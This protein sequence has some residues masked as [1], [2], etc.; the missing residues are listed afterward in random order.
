MKKMDEQFWIAV[1]E[2]WQGFTSDVCQDTPRLV[3]EV[4]R[5]EA[6][7]ERVGRL[8]R[9]RLTPDSIGLSFAAFA[10]GIEWA[11]EAKQE[12]DSALTTGVVT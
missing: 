6:R 8:W 4:G 9:R 11:R 3:V 10:M 5:V 2:L 1:G 7:M 12:L